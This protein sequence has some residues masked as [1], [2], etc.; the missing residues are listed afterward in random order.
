L[1]FRKHQDLEI[2]MRPFLF[3]SLA[4]GFVACLG[5]F[6]QASVALVNPS[7]EVGW[8]QGIY[9]VNST[10]F[11]APSTVGWAGVAND[12]NGPAPGTNLML[13]RDGSWFAWMGG[14]AVL[15]SWYAERA[16]IDAGTTYQL[17]F[18]AALDWEQTGSATF[19]MQF[20]NTNGSNNDLPM[21][22]FDRTLNQTELP[23][24]NGNSTVTLQ[25]FSITGTAPV[26]AT[27]VGLWMTS[28]NN[29]VMD[30]FAVTAVPEPTS[31]ATLGFGLLSATALRRLKSYRIKKYS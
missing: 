7:F 1:F 29:I 2:F 24:R 30:N 31:L 6:S 11:G 9:H 22:S 4:L 23:T 15:K 13:G 16:S 19:A 12:Q 27:Y 25:T 14:G 8:M 18:K 20:F 26:G 28:N 21:I 3:L 17:T 10:A 5:T